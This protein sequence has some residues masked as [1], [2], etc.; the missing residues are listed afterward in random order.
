[1]FDTPL[2]TKATAF[3]PST[4]RFPPPASRHFTKASHSLIHTPICTSMI[5]NYDGVGFVLPTL[6]STYNPLHLQ[7]HGRPLKWLRSEASLSQSK[8]VPWK[9]SPLSWVVSLTSFVVMC[10]SERRNTKC[11]DKVILYMYLSQ[12]LLSKDY[13]P[14]LQ[15]DFI[16]ATFHQD[17]SLGLSS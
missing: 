4:A 15:L 7:S 9:V 8:G 10:H 13:S 5:M 12:H 2:V 6:R 11:Q 1:M 3:P 17:N 16:L 14:L